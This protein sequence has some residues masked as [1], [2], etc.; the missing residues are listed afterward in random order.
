MER[1]DRSSLSLNIGNT[2]VWSREGRGEGTRGG[3]EGGEVDWEERRRMNMIK[4]WE[5]RRGVEAGE[6][7]EEIEE[8]EEVWWGRVKSTDLGSWI[9]RIFYH[10]QHDV[11]DFKKT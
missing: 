11:S 5:I 1:A 6:E 4:N 8:E 3:G 7:V 9:P 2:Q 10:G